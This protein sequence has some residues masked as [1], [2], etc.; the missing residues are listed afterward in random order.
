MVFARGFGCLRE[1]F[2]VVIVVMSLFCWVA[3]GSVIALI[4]LINEGIL[5]TFGV[6]VSVGTLP[7]HSS[8]DLE[9]WKLEST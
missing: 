1:G 2:P 8:V 4:G 3:T 7:V 6:D 5:L 9:V